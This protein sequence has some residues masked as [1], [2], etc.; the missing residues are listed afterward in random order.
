M[1]VMNSETR[2]IGKEGCPESKR[3]SA[4]LERL[5]PAST[6]VCENCGTVKTGIYLHIPFCRA[7]C[8]YCDF[9]TY[10][11]LEN[12]FEPY[13]RALQREIISTSYH[14]IT[15]SSKRLPAHTLF[16]GGGTPSLL[17]PEWIGDLIR[18]CRERFEIPQEIE[19]TME[20]NP[21]TVTLDYLKQLRT[22]GVTR[23][24]FG[25]QSADPAELQLLGRE[26]TFDQVGRA[27]AWAREASFDNV[28]FDLI[29]GLPR[30][31]LAT[32][33]HT[34]DTALQLEPD[35]ISL[36]A[37]TIENGT[38]MHD[39]VRRGEVP[40]PDP[41]AAADMYDYAEQTMQSL[42]YDHY[43]IS[44]WCRPGH[45]CEHNL[46]YWH[47]EPYFGFGA[48]AH[49]STIHAGKGG[50]RWWKVRRPA[51]YIG[52]AE[53]G[54][55]L[56]MNHEDLDE[57]TSRGETIVLGLRLLNEGVGQASFAER[58]GA[59]L[60]ALYEKELIEG[61]KLGLLD[62]TDERVTLTPKGHFLSNRVME[63]F[64]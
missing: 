57:R 9:N 45:E 34:L 20:C 59:P 16:I 25:A 7:R 62:I 35:H 3:V 4:I 13:V 51:D 23:L 26:H 61:H 8:T 2:F 15:P 63:M 31:Q 32:W 12:L 64:V 52:K 28:N 14:P 10:I 18:S 53:H 36:Y 56:E 21:G 30:Q 38:P 42:G 47:N 54:E 5:R 60:A 37:L 41:D 6:R 27:V 11:G 48:G 40:Y 19:C 55:S 58:Y 43:E 17:R 46:V 1:Q 29:F 24:S 33:Q 49:S 39:W 50:R 22:Q 44:N